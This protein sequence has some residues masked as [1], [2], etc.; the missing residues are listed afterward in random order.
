MSNKEIADRFGIA[1]TTVKTHSSRII[2][3]LGVKRRGQ[4]VVRARELHLIE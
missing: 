3:K 2:G 1:E 4:A